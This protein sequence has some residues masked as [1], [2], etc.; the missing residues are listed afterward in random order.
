M[1]LTNEEEKM[2]AGEEGYGVQKNMQ[3]LTALGEI[4]GAEKMIP[5]T[6]VQVQESHTT[7]LETRV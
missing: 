1:H 4:F 7:I 2:L 5:V 6:S 3:I